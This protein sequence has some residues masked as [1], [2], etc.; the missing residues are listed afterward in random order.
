ML[1]KCGCLLQLMLW[2]A[3][4][5]GW[6]SDVAAAME[7]GCTWCIPLQH[8]GALLGSFCRVLK[9]L[10]ILLQ[11]LLWL[12]GHAARLQMGPRLQSHLHPG[13]PLSAT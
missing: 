1:S 7:Q 8:P 9:A 5:R 3:R 12:H 4:D 6:V 2:D 11:V 10:Q 13:L